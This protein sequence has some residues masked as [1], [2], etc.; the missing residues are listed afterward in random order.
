M[1]KYILGVEIGGTKL[2]LRG[3]KH[4]SKIIF[5]RCLTE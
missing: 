2:Q 4:G 5:R 3:F 1:E